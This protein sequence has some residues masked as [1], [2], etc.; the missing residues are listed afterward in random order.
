MLKLSKITPIPKSGD[1][2]DMSN[3]RLVSILPVFS[4]ILK[5]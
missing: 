5:R 2:R 3:F 4:K 1:V